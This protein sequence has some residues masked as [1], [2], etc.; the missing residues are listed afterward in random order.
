MSGNVHEWTWDWYQETY[1]S[2]EPT[3]PAVDPE[4]PGSAS[5]RSFRGGGWNYTARYCRSAGRGR[6]TPGSRNPS[7]GFRLAKSE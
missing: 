2:G 3:S 1:P 4:G 6:A 5:Y 7:I